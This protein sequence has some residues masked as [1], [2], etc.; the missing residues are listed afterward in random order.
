MTHMV[1]FSLLVIRRLHAKA[2]PELVS[3]LLVFLISL[4]VILT[5]AGLD[6][7]G[8]MRGGAITCRTVL[9][10]LPSLLACGGA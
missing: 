5:W 1:G 4:R 3:F 10:L 7:A 6:G 8:E 9:I 2:I